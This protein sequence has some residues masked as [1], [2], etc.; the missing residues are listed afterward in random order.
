MLTYVECLEKQ[1]YAP[2]LDHTYKYSKGKYLLFTKST[3]TNTSFP[4]TSHLDLKFDKDHCLT[5]WYYEDGEDPFVL[6]VFNQLP[7]YNVLVHQYDSA[8]ENRR[9]W[10]LVKA[11]VMYSSSYRVNS[12]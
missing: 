12:K 10:S 4:I 1:Y 3:S 9:R 7:K 2:Q 11:D 8:I 5:F 6:Q